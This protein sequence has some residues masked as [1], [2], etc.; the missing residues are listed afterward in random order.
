M[1]F[2]ILFPFFKEFYKFR[3]YFQYMI[4]SVEI[5]TDDLQCIPQCKELNFTV[6]YWWMFYVLDNAKAPLQPSKLIHFWHVNNK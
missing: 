1:Q 2:L 6:N 3:I 4:F 5:H